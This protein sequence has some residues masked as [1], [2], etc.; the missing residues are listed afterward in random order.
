MAQYLIQDTTLTAVADQIR[1]L[2]GTTGTIRGD[3]LDDQLGYAI[4]T[5]ETQNESLLAILE[6]ANSLNDKEEGVDTSDAT[7]V[8]ADIRSGQTAYVAGG[9]V[10]GTMSQYSALSGVS[11]AAS[12]N[13]SNYMGS[14]KTITL[15]GMVHNT[16]YISNPTVTLSAPANKFGN[17]TAED[18]AAGKTFTSAAGLRIVG[19]AA[20]SSPINVFQGVVEST[21]D[22]VIDIPYPAGFV[23][24]EI[25]LWNIKEIDQWEET[26]DDSLVRYL[27]DGVM[28]GAIRF[29]NNR[30]ISQQMLSNS[31]TTIIA[32]AS[33]ERAPYQD[34]NY[35]ECGT[36]NILDDGETITWA[37]GLD[38]YSTDGGRTDLCEETF[39]YVLIG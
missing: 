37:L 1:T 20:T 21:Q 32:Q 34:Q 14:T 15:T 36:T 2:R 8:A 3:R 18:V 12:V 23:P 24:N 25:L 10:T 39:N 6:Q 22:G 5:V 19:T 31:G 11:P 33:A 29:G 35:Q 28:L 17:A 30:W 16:G 27:Y 9:K 7:A 13:E 4:N 38:P 26:G